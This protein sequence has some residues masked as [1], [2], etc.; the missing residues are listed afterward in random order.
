MNVDGGRMIH[1]IIIIIIMEDVYSKT[2]HISY[3][4]DGLMVSIFREHVHRYT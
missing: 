1:Q 4:R 2:W 3:K